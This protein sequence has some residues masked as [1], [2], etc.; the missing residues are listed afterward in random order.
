MPHGIEAIRRHIREVDNVPLLV[1][2]FT[3]STPETIQKMLEI[4]REYGESVLAIGSGYRCYHSSIFQS[5]NIAS[6]LVC[7]PGLAPSIPGSERDLIL[8][9]SGYDAKRLDRNDVEFVFRLIGLG[10]FNLLQKDSHQS[11]N[12]SALTRMFD[13]FILILFRA[14]T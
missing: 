5:A 9:F 10:T 6:S 13:T 3:D 11:G 1:S 4:F 2:L 12:S 7:L 8:R 14:A